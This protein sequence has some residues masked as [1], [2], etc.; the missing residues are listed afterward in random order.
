MT[1]RIAATFALLAVAGVS[2]ARA[3]FKDFLTRCTPGSM[4]ACANLQVITTPDGSGG[5]NVIIR[6]RNLAGTLDVGNLDNTGGSLITRIGLVA[7]QIMGASGLTVNAV[8]GASSVGS[9]AGFWM[10]RNPGGLGGP[11]ELT[12]GITPG[13]TSG[14]VAG[15]LPSYS[16]Y[17][18]D[19]FET[20]ALGGWIEFS[21]N[22]TNSW[23]ANQAEVAWLIQDANNPA[24]F[25]EECGSDPTTSTP[26]G[27]SYCAVTPEPITMVLLGSGLAGMGGF[28][29]LRRRR[30]DTGVE[31]G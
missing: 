10:L 1:K 29:A 21:F 13:T 26:G 12:A 9:P 11:I 18:A 31:N 17:Q 4:R 14:G 22:T 2:T 7:P 27:R 30:K 28:G 25:G 5:T 3:D 6:L 20:C 16:G 8:G 19:R 15:C 23:S 24:G